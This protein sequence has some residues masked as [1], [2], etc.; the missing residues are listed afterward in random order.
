MIS[1]SS[2]D[3]DAQLLT[4]FR[5]SGRTPVRPGQGGQQTGSAQ[6]A[7]RLWSTGYVPEG[8]TSFG[9]DTYR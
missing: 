9:S 7:S 4:A 3:I 6:S 5:A 2:A 8:N 1:P